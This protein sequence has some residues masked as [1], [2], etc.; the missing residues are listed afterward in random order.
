M[1]SIFHLI[2]KLLL[3]L[4][5]FFHFLTFDQYYISK[6]FINNEIF[7]FFFHQLFLLL[8]RWLKNFIFIDVVSHWVNKDISIWASCKNKF[9]VWRNC[10]LSNFSMMSIKFIKVLWDQRKVIDFNV[11]FLGTNNQV[12]GSTDGFNVSMMS[13]FGFFGKEILNDFFFMIDH[14]NI[15]LCPIGSHYN[16]F[17]FI[18]FIFRKTTWTEALLLINVT[19]IWSFSES[20]FCLKSNNVAVSINYWETSVVFIKLKIGDIWSC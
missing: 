8:G 12:L 1:L 17:D 7:I 2:F 5:P 4:R 10:N 13:A 14:F 15:S 11:S 20:A 6:C 18:V 19:W 3:L 16:N 9:W